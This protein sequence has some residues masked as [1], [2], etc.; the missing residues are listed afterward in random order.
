M[1]INGKNL[2]VFGSESLGII[3]YHCSNMIIGRL[4]GIHCEGE[5]SADI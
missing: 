3:T 2:L 1:Y 5:P 4:K